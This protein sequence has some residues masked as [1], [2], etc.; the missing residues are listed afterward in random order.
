MRTQVTWSEPDRVL[1]SDMMPKAPHQ[2][3][4]VFVF[5]LVISSYAVMAFNY[6][7]AYIWATYEDL[8]GE[9]CQTY[10]FLAATLLSVR[11]AIQKTRYRW[12]FV[13]FALAAL[14]VVLEEIS[15]GQR[16]FGFATP[17]FLKEH[18][19]QGEANLHN[20]FTGPYSTMLKDALSFAVAAGLVA[21]GLLFPLALSRRWR[22]ACFADAMGVAAP[23]IGLWPMFTVAAYF[24]LK[25]LSFNEAEIAELLVAVAL[26]ATA[27]HYNFAT[28]RFINPTKDSEL[29][30]NDSLILGRLLISMAVSV[31]VLAGITTV[32]FYSSPS[33]KT[34][35]DGRIDR[36]MEKFAGRYIRYDRC[37]IANE[38]YL[39][40][41]EKQP[42]R[43][44]LNRRI[45]ECYQTTG[46]FDLF[47]DYI[48]RAINIDLQT[49]SIEPWRASVNRSLVRSY[50][51]AGDLDKVKEHL[52]LALEIGFRRIDER[53]ESASAAYSLGQTL[54]LANRRDEAV[55]RFKLAFE[56]DRSS[57][58]Y[59]KAY[60]AVR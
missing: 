60:Y 18:N 30:R 28:T 6:P 40:L 10:F 58:K 25:P 51:L 39:K 43:V 53:P 22:I 20:V 46:E 32:A 19:L 33:N 11:V 29:D 24:E 23:P 2:Y 15:W 54:L 21:Y 8:I 1:R 13:L 14:Y 5:L 16:I 42:D 9:W 27:L 56:T 57:S 50:R 17:E 12:F 35:I 4:V 37:D 36:G 38:L 31:F 49:Y 44:S 47:D 52:D 55:E 3:V 26:A 59:R 45:A 7:I 41:L 34:V 48:Q